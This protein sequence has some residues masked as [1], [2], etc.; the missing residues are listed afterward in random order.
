MEIRKHKR[1]RMFGVFGILIYMNTKKQTQ[2]KIRW[3]SPLRIL[4][5]LWNLVTL[6]FHIFII[7]ISSIT[8]IVQHIIGMVIEYW[9]SG[10]FE[11]SIIRMNKVINQKLK[12]VKNRRIKGI[13]IKYFAFSTIFTITYNLAY[14]IRMLVLYLIGYNL[15]NGEKFTIAIL[16]SL[17][18]GFTGGPILAFIVSYV[19]DKRLKIKIIKKSC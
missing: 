14:F 17:L 7:N 9:L 8:S 11:N 4:V 18:F 13:I 6:A 3:F 15:L 12:N 5:L 19:R 2:Q 16:T 1:K 10:I